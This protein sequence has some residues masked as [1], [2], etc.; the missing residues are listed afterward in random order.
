MRLISVPNDLAAGSYRL[1]TNVPFRCG[2]SGRWD[3][4]KSCCRSWSYGETPAPRK[5]GPCESSRLRCRLHHQISLTLVTG[6]WR[7]ANEHCR[8]S[9]SRGE[10]EDAPARL[11]TPQFPANRSSQ[12]SFSTYQQD[13]TPA[14]LLVTSC[15]QPGKRPRSGAITRGGITNSTG[16]LSRTTWR[17]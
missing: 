15:F 2:D 5:S 10:L 16:R 12:P 1:I 14:L 3:I 11:I 4:S 9:T 17:P 6:E 7:F 8:E 13:G